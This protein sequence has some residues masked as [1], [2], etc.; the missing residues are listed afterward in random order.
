MNAITQ[1]IIGPRASAELKQV[2]PLRF[3][4]PAWLL[5]AAAGLLLVSLF[6]PYWQIT[7]FAPQ[8]PNGLTVTS[9]V[10]H[11]GGRVEEV[12]ILN[13]YIG[14]KPLEAAA[15]MEKKFGVVLI[16]AMA[17]L[18][19]AAVKIH[20]PFAAL[21][22]LPAALFPVIFLADLQFWLADFGL[23]LDPHAP[24]NMSVQPFVPRVLGVGYVGQF[25]SVALPCSGLILAVLAA[26]LILTGLWLQ[27]RAYKSLRN[28]QTTATAKGGPE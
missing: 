19:I 7:M 4:L 6:R 1:H 18:V 22:S 15:P 10:N 11:V 14:M 5:A 21:L 24:L 25:K 3:R 26:I 2:H 12:D 13:Q 17:L 16:A 20:S 27:R 8:Y 28:R 9:Y 23:H